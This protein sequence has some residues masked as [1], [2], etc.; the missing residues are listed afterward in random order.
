[1]SCSQECPVRLLSDKNHHL[2][3][4]IPLTYHLSQLVR[5]LGMPGNVTALAWHPRLNQIFAGTGGGGGA[6]TEAFQSEQ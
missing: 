3:L 1:M 6:V 5:K 2:R 4:Q